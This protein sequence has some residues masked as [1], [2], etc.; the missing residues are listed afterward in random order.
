MCSI[1]RIRHKYKPEFFLFLR[2][3][4]LIFI[5]S[6]SNCRF[7]ENQRRLWRRR[8]GPSISIRRPSFWKNIHLLNF[9]FV[10][11]AALHSCQITATASDATAAATATTTACA[12]TTVIRSCPLSAAAAAATKST[13]SYPT[14]NADAATAATSPL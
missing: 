7:S 6:C 8:W 4:S 13:A 9:I 2:E 11:P 5:I 1:T 12:T 14:A 3:H 10:F